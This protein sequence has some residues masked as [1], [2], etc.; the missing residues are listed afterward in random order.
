MSSVTRRNYVSS[1]R[2]SAI[3][4]L[5]PL[6]IAL[7][8]DSD[9]RAVTCRPGGAAPFSAIKSNIDWNRAPTSADDGCRNSLC[10][11]WAIPYSATE[12]R[13]TGRIAKL[14][15]P[16]AHRAP[17]RQPAARGDRR[18]AMRYSEDT[19]SESKVKTKWPLRRPKSL[20]GLGAP[21]KTTSA[22]NEP[23]TMPPDPV[24]ARKS[25]Q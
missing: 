15:S 12:P 25:T 20:L 24:A 11:T 22:I 14:P 1:I 4:T 6:S 16:I 10:P 2:K 9:S 8:A 19:C 17:K 18:A 7:Q 13:Y 21:S 3:V 5:A 23:R